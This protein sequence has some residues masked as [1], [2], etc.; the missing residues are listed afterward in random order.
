MGPIQSITTCLRKSFDFSGRAT[1][2]EFWWFAPVGVTLPV[3]AC[4]FL[5]PEVNSTSALGVKMLMFLL[6]AMPLNA[7]ASRRFHDTNEPHDELWRGIGPTIGT[8]FAAYFASFGLFAISTGWGMAIGILVF[9][10]SS[11]IFAVCLF[12]APGTLGATFGQL[13]VP[14]TPGPNRYGPNPLEVTP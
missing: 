1:R 4:V 8:I 6:F 2:A 7:A 5:Q 10:P 11:L 9:I 13:L 12:L 3:I 14:S